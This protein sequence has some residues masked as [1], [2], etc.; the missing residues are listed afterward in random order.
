MK[1]LR[2]VT[3]MPL[4]NQV[5]LLDLDTGLAVYWKLGTSLNTSLYTIG[6]VYLVEKNIITKA[7]K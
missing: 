6:D 4:K 5:E 7:I 2:I 1:K 3:L